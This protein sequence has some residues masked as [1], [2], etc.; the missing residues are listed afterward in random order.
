M[1]I[2]IDEEKAFDKIRHPFMIEILQK[3]DI[4]GTYLKIIK[5][6]VKNSHLTSHKI[7]KS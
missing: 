1:I 3:E 4:K 6:I 7:M 5:A 2:S